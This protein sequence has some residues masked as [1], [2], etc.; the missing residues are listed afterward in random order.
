MK[1][2]LKKVLVILLLI[3]IL[4]TSTL[5]SVSAE[6]NHSENRCV[7]ITRRVNEKIR[8]FEKIRTRYMSRYDRITSS[9]SMLVS[10]LKDNGYD[11][12]QLETD[13]QTLKNMKTELAQEFT[14]FMS[15]LR[16]V[17]D[18]ACENNQAEFKNQLQFARGQ[19]LD[20]REKALEM[21][22]FVST[23]IIDDLKD[24]RNQ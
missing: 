6:S 19:L 24:I 4:L 9:L 17:K 14:E 3:P 16:A 5:V 11:T 12:T 22:S 10:K 18:Y 1:K 23:T 8:T 2:D 13:L 20:L 21:R 15:S 7:R